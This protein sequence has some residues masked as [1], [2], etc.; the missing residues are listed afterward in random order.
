[1]NHVRAAAAKNIKNAV[2][3]MRNMN[4][5]IR[6][7][8]EEDAVCQ[9]ADILRRGGLVAFPTETV[10]GLGGNGLDPLACRRIYA[11]KG[12]PS[13]N[14]LILHIASKEQLMEIVSMVPPVAQRAMDAFWPGPLTL[15]FQKAQCVP[16]SVTG[17][18]DTVAVRFPSHPL[19]QR[20]IRK[21]GL[22]IAAP[23]ANSSGKPSPTRASH[24]EFDLSGKIDMI[25]DGG[26]CQVGLEST[27]LDVSGKTPV[28]LRPGAVTKEMIEMAIGPISIDPAVFAKPA[29]GILPKAPG[30]KYTHYSPKAA[31][32]L[33]EGTS[34]ALVVERINELVVEAQAQGKKVGVMATE[35]TKQMYTGGVVLS[36]GD[37]N[38]PAAIGANLFKLLRKFDYLNID[39]VYSEV[40]PE[41]DEGMAIMN[42]LNKAAGYTKIHCG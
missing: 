33:V 38:Q 35:Q 26:P 22:P 1:M 17:G 37:R 15:V 10:Y 29:E 3:Q 39:V 13:D 27:I 32:T 20:L 24:V 6:N 9:A 7:A 11:A 19:A 42:R 31:V 18:L 28:L 34:L 2:E 4:T 16:L 12:R 14:P 25:L 40:F 8:D 41:T 21:A 36:L 30:M 5:I 23:S